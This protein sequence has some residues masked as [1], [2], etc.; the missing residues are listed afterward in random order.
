MNANNMN[1]NA[2]NANNMNNQNM[3]NQNMNN[4]NMNNMNSF[5]GNSNQQFGNNRNNNR[6]VL[7]I[8]WL[9][10]SYMKED[11]T[12]EKS[13]NALKLAVQLGKSSYFNDKVDEI[14]VKW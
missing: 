6:R 5:R 4:Q 14:K 8:A 1:A 10:P 2:M 7:R 3:N 11:Y 13:V 9:A 12:A